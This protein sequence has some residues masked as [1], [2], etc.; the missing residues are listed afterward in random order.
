VGRCDQ[1]VGT[2]K[3]KKCRHTEM[4]LLPVL[5]SL[6]SR[7][8]SRSSAWITSSN[9][10]AMGSSFS[11]SHAVTL[12]DMQLFASHAL[13]YCASCSFLLRRL[14]ADPVLEGAR[15]LRLANGAASA[16]RRELAGDIVRVS[17]DAQTERTRRR[18][19]HERACETAGGKRQAGCCDAAAV[20]LEQDRAM[21]NGAA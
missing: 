18:M 21:A 17:R 6:M 19:A 10:S 20:V 8:P 7:R 12:P 2:A 13:P 11:D 9:I 5:F 3:T 15:V 16:A 4:G 14:S 1:N